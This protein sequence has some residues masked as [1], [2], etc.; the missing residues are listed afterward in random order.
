MVYCFCDYKQKLATQLSIFLPRL[1]LS[2][3]IILLQASVVLNDRTESDIRPDR[4][5]MVMLFGQVIDHD[6]TLTPLR[7][8]AD[9]EFLDCCSPQNFA[10]PECC[11]I[12]VAKN[13]PFYSAPGR[14]LCLPFLRSRLLLFPGM[15]E[16]YFSK[17]TT[18]ESDLSGQQF[19]IVFLQRWII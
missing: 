9:G 7:S 8:T 12:T 1:L 5:M 15:L 11:P 17:L 2:N 3:Q 6:I 10:A 18:N 14:T 16:K 13:D 4:S 19:D